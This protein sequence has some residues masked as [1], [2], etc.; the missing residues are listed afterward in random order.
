MQIRPRIAFLF[1]SLKFGGGERVALNLASALKRE[2]YSIDFLL[3]SKEGE[4][5]SEA[6]EQ[7]NVIDLRCDRTWK[8]PFQLWKYIV[9]TRPTALISSFWKLNLCA[10]LTRAFCQN[11]RL[12][13]WEHS[14]P[15]RSCPAWLY[16]VTASVF[17]RLA[18]R[19]VAVSSG[20]AA[21]IFSNTK[22]LKSLV[23][24]IFNPIPGPSNDK[25]SPSLHNGRKIIWVGRLDVP[26]NPV[27]M[28]DAF[29]LLPRSDGYKL[30]FV[31]DGRLMTTLLERARELNCE[32]SVRFLGFR[33]NVYECM[34]DADML[35][36]SSDREGL[37][38]VLVEA[39]HAGLRIVS[40]DCGAGV[41]DILL[42]NR[43]GT[44]V[45]TKDK[46]ALAAAIVER[47]NML[48]DPKMQI[49]EAQ[50]FSPS[51]IAKQFLHAM[52]LGDIKNDQ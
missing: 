1:S 52:G 10:C 17:Y 44:I 2:G 12:I 38:T 42:K 49:A 47:M 16:A 19:V 26:K 5:L 41:H 32:C 30:D 14:P 50:R 46:F 13:A 39:M 23:S 27:L 28:L 8:L 25:L 43:L 18:N 29:A 34:A 24:V 4:F 20:V 31:G 7:F 37:P 36:L 9:R 22:G 6:K 51:R 15:T 3:M 48:H 11:V 33:S 35:V 40:T 21:D 45:P